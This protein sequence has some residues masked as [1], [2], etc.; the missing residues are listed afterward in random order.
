[1]RESNSAATYNGTTTI[2]LGLGCGNGAAES[3][4]I[5]ESWSAPFEPD[6]EEAAS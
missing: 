3:V 5:L 6:E 4:Y 1:M 2:D